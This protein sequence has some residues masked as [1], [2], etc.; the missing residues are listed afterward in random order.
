MDNKIK[1]LQPKIK[2]RELR[3]I[4]KGELLF[5]KSLGRQQEKLGINTADQD[6]ELK[7]I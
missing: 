3:A 2:L 1:N 5:N 6:R 4:Q 7:K